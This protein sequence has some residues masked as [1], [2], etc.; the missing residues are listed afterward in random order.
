MHQVFVGVG[1]NINRKSNICKAI[2][3]LRELYPKLYCS[4]VYECVAWGFDGND[5]YN[6]TIGF[7]T[8]QTLPEIAHS[9]K[10]LERQL[11]RAQSKL[12]RTLDLDPLMYD[13]EISPEYAIPREDILKYWFVL[14]P[15][16]DIAPDL[17]HPI[18]GKTIAELRNAFD[19]PKCVLH[20]VGLHLP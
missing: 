6:L 12:S 18:L 16:S 14:K 19:K 11:D 10:R 15:L 3:A 13:D 2:A 17:Q 1:S 8:E 20:D 9:L 7:A 4:P 5:F